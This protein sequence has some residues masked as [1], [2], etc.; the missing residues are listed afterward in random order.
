M[1]WA[2]RA[3]CWASVTVTTFDPKSPVPGWWQSA[4]L[5]LSGDHGEHSPPAT[6]VSWTWVPSGSAVTIASVPSARRVL[7]AIRRPS[8]DQSGTSPHAS[9]RGHLPGC[10]RRSGPAG[11]W[12]AAS[13][14]RWWASGRGLLAAGWCGRGRVGRRPVGGACLSL[15]YPAPAATIP[16]VAALPS[17]S[18]CNFR[19]ARNPPIR[20]RTTPACSGSSCWTVI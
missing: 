10:C 3:S 20:P 19:K 11:S 14:E 6:P 18:A 12:R 17:I 4:S 13:P 7:K 1:R 5:E 9:P 2:R 15:R 8:G 16:P